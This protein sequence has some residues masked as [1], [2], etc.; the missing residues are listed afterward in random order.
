MLLRSD[1]WARA[2]DAQPRNT[3]GGCELVV[4]H[5]I[6]ADERACPAQTRLA[7][8]RNG[9]ITLLRQIQK[10]FDQMVT[11][12]AAINKKQIMMLEAGLSKPLGIVD[13]LIQP[14]DT[15]D[16]VFSKISKVSLRCM[17]WVTWLT[18]KLIN[19][20]KIDP[21][22]IKKVRQTIFNLAFGM[23]ATEGKKLFWQ[24]PVEVAVLHLLI[25]F[26]LVDIEAL[27]VEEAVEEGLV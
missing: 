5:Q 12:R 10:F 27:K 26:V 16:V 18:K 14:D 21:T 4:L 15:L 25:V 8:H 19:C 20:N 11:R 6:A 17:Q 7:M 22:W 13:L 1:N 23:R 9:A 2:T 24:D 3:L